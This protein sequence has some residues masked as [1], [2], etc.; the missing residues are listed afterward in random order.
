MLSPAV[1][2]TLPNYSPAHIAKKKFK[3]YIISAGK[4]IQLEI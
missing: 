1:N 3:T 2:N 4:Y